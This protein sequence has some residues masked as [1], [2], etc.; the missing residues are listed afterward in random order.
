MFEL[1]LAIVPAHNSKHMQLVPRF[2]ALYHND[3]LYIAHHLLGVAERL[4]SLHRQPEGRP[5]TYK[6]T[7]LVD[8]ILMYRKEAYESITKQV[9]GDGETAVGQLS[10]V[11][12]H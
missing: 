3:C 4:Y 12:A 9:V 1:F 5:T 6:D 8:L 2:A 10:A 11:G 7:N